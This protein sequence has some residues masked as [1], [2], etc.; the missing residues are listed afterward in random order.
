MTMMIQ[1]IY[2]IAVVNMV[3][4]KTK[5]LALY[6]TTENESEEWCPLGKGV[7]YIMYMYVGVC[8]RPVTCTRKSKKGDILFGHDTVQL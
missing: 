8:R 1:T 4:S 2:K 3:L 7:H 6:G 5:I